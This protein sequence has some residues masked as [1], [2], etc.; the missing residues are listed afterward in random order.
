MSRIIFKSNPI[1]KKWAFPNLYGSGKLYQ[2]IKAKSKLLNKPYRTP[3]VC[4][5]PVVAF[6]LRTKYEKSPHFKE[7]RI[8]V[9]MS[10]GGTVG[11]DMMELPGR[12][13]NPSL[14]N[15]VVFP[16]GNETF[17]STKPRT[18]M[19]SYLEAGYP[20]V[21][22]A[23]C[24]GKGHTAL[25]S[26]RFTFPF[27]E[28][29]DVHGVVEGLE[30][31]F[32]DERWLL[33]G[34]CYGGSMILDYLASAKSE[35]DS[36][37]GGVVHSMQWDVERTHERNMKDPSFSMFTKPWVL[38]NR[39]KLLTEKAGEEEVHK[40]ILELIGDEAV[41]EL[42][43][44]KMET[45]AEIQVLYN[46]GL[47][48]L[49][50]YSMNGREDYIRLF[51]CDVKVPTITK[52]LMVINAVDDIT[53]PMNQDDITNIV[54]NPNLCLWLFAAGGH[55]AY[56]KSLFPLTNWIDDVMVECSNIVC[57]TEL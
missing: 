28:F 11:V 4:L 57:E 31:K 49:T 34:S 56:V 14:P 27:G 22:I 17:K 30:E 42:R 53:F 5:N 40:Q 13:I 1:I 6:V 23:N 55:C 33:S 10:D 29:N 38:S 8:L 46:K 50:G 44:S 21:F 37:I 7:T 48:P 12:T 35:R 24:R 19:R 51:S 54:S 2:A 36:V 41:E 9:P 16:G 25:T 39:D 15:V 45:E 3:L 52:P 18:L 47:N 43:N 20:R 32:K 26:P